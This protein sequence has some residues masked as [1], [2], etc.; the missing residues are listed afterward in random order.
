MSLALMEEHTGRV[1]TGIFGP[2]RNE[3][4]GWRK[5]EYTGPM[6]VIIF[7]IHQT[8]YYYWYTI[9]MEWDGHT[10]RTDATINAHTWVLNVSYT[11]CIRSLGFHFT[12]VRM[13]R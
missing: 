2:E 9:K 6:S 3:A 4:L 11:Q 10:A 1:V 12:S 8:G 13:N 5:Y 7:T